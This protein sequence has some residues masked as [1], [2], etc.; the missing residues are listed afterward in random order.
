MAQI[1]QGQSHG[2]VQTLEAGN[3]K[4]RGDGT[5]ACHLRGMV[6][7]E[8]T[9][10]GC[11]VLSEARLEEHN[12][13]SGGYRIDYRLDGAAASAVMASPGQELCRRAAMEP[14]SP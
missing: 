5:A 14:C 3:S 4:L 1:V 6:P 12:C 7:D 13:A 10:Y 11:A 9:A 2:S 8:E